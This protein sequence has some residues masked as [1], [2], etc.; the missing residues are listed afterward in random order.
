MLDGQQRGRSVV[1]HVERARRV[2]AE[3]A[4]GRALPALAD[5]R[6]ADAVERSRSAARPLDL[7][8]ERKIRRLHIDVLLDIRAVE[9]MR[10]DDLPVDHESHA[11][12]ADAQPLKV[13]HEDLHRVDLEIDPAR[14]ERPTGP[15]QR[16]EVPRRLRH[17][18][19]GVARRRAPH[20]TKPRPDDGRAVQFK[21]EAVSRVEV[22]DALDRVCFDVV[23][24]E[25]LEDELALAGLIVEE[26]TCLAHRRFWACTRRHTQRHASVWLIVAARRC[27]ARLRFGPVE[28]L[29]VVHEFAVEDRRRVAD[30]Q[31]PECI[32]VRRGESRGHSTPHSRAERGVDADEKSRGARDVRRVAHF[33][34]GRLNCRACDVGEVR[35]K[36]KSVSPVSVS[37]CRAAGC[38]Q[39]T[40]M[41]AITCGLVGRRAGGYRSSTDSVLK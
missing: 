32:E 28:R 37:L 6:P 17:G 15:V 36:R 18:H 8:P 24:V 5:H 3:G 19:V 41:V 38:H 4:A 2:E 31:T 22:A 25:R 40:G 23:R 33:Q 16:V 13:D 35:V 27:A 21:E 20:E 11:R 26:T 1:R 14:I 10:V 9:A 30:A 34:R 7:V 29:R 12:R 39:G